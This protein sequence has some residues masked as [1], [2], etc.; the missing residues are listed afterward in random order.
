MQATEVIEPNQWTHVALTYDGSSH[1]SGLKL[2]VNGQSAET[3][4]I[5]D[6]LYKNIT[7]GGGD[8]IT[9]GQRFRDIGFANGQVDD[10]RVFDR[11]LTAPEVGQTFNGKALTKLT[12]SLE[13]ESAVAETALR[14]FAA[15]IDKRYKE[16]L[17]QLAKAREAF[18]KAQDSQTEIMVMQERPRPRQAYVLNRGAYDDRGD[19]VGSE[20]PAVFPGRSDNAPANRLGLAYWLTSDEHPL[21]AR[22]AVNRFWQMCFG[23]GLVRTPEDFGSQG[24]PPTHPKLLDWLANDF[25]KNGWNVK[26][27]I[28]QMVMSATYQQSSEATKEQIR[29]DPENLFLTRA[30]VMRLPAEMIRDNALA[31]S[32]LLQ[33]SIGGAPARPYE[34][35]ASFKPSNPDDGPG[36][37][38]RSLYTY[39][40]R[41]APAPVMMTLDASKREVCRVKR[42]RTASPLQ[43][44]VI[45]NG[46]QFVEASRV[47]A[48]RLLKEHGDNDHRI[49]AEMFQLLTGQE[50]S[51]ND[52]VILMRLLKEQTQH[53]SADNDAAQHYLSIGRKKLESKNPSRLAAWTSVANTLLA[54]DECVTR[55]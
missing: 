38:R 33:K 32:G 41:T 39:W 14:Y 10:F 31:V 46:P 29:R 49:L 42:E 8:T 48:D 43:A 7:G 45:L 2:W 24:M 26:R 4:V 23:D 22:V 6:N 53:F 25:R 40:K 27:L 54:F 52:A 18:C 15:T 50:P 1:A 19:A 28:K 17:S 36:L 51:D 20:V 37:Y 11:Q 47:L 3:E 34:L 16:R 12:E 35:A 5:R 13:R 30:S 9:I 21:T 44:L 55:R